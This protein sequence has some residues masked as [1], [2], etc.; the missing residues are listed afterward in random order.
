MVHLVCFSG[1]LFYNWANIIIVHVVFFKLHSIYMVCVVNS[2]IIKFVCKLMNSK[3]VSKLWLVKS[4]DRPNSK[5][6]KSETLEYKML[7]KLWKE[8][9]IFY[10][11][12]S[13]SMKMVYH[14]RELSRFLGEVSKLCLN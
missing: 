6:S 7:G 1:D 5:L 12:N 14:N 9:I 13:W 10:T 4:F 8:Q 11:V 2:Y 3:I